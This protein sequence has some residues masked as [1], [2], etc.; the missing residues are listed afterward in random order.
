MEKKRYQVHGRL[1]DGRVFR[2]ASMFVECWAAAFN[3]PRVHEGEIE[4]TEYFSVRSWAEALAAEGFR[5]EYDGDEEG[6]WV[7]RIAD[8]KAVDILYY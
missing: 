5:M 1:E 7:I 2:M 3:D 8:G 4:A 6:F